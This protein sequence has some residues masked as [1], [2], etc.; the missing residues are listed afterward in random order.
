MTDST[1]VSGSDAGLPGDIN[2]TLQVGSVP[3]QCGDLLV[4]RVRMTAGT[5]GYIEF[6]TSL[7][8]P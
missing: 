4:L 7:S 6:H 8:V 1:V 5:S 2:A 3:A